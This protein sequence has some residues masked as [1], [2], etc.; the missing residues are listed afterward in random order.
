[1]QWGDSWN[2]QQ[3][4]FV[5][6]VLL[7]NC[8]SCG[9]KI[10]ISKSGKQ[11]KQSWKTLKYAAILVVLWFSYCSLLTALLGG[12]YLQFLLSLIKLLN[13]PTLYFLVSQKTHSL[14]RD[15]SEGPFQVFGKWGILAC[16]VNVYCEP[17]QGSGGGTGLLDTD[18]MLVWVCATW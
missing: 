8:P 13:C 1:M 11:S 4:L 18:L 16:L 12:I 17:D 9:V 10:G 5:D 2:V 6:S 3:A 14:S 15:S 7:K